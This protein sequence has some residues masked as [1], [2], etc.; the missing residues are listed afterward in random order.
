EVTKRMDG[1]VATTVVVT[2]GR[3]SVVAGGRQRLLG[4]GSRWS[5][6][7]QSASPPADRPPAPPA[8]DIAARR[9]PHAF[10]AGGHRSTLHAESDL[11]RAALIAERDGKHAEAIDL[12]DRLLRHYPN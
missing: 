10:S 6:A 5:S 11:F 7:E 9:P 4:P 2:E 12:T 1:N 8:P 3:V